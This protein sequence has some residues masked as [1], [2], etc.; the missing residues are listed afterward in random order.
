M[1]LEWK[2]CTNL[3]DL[4]ETSSNT[5][6]TVTKSIATSYNICKDS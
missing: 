1:I 3:D 2:H 5:F 4:N 6:P